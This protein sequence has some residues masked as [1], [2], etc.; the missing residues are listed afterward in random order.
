[1]RE[2]LLFYG[3]ILI[4]INKVVYK[5]LHR[6][7]YAVFDVCFIVLLRWLLRPVLL[8]QRRSLCHRYLFV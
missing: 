6:E 3:S 2:L 7:C 5:K 8:A 1:M 4:F